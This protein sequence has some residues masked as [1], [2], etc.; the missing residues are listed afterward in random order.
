MTGA[1][2]LELRR[3]AAREA[4]EAEK[5]RLAQRD[6]RRRRDWDHA[7]EL[8]AVLQR[9]HGNLAAA[10]RMIGLSR[11]GVRARMER[12]RIRTFR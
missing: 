6:E 4:L 5:R 8:C 7:A 9:T 11:S 12:L 2:A 1:E 10:A 3:R